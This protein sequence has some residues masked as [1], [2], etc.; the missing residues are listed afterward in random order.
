MRAVRA[1]HKQFFAAA[2]AQ[3]GKLRDGLHHAVVVRGYDQERRRARICLQC[4]FCSGKIDDAAASGVGE[5]IRG[6]ECRFQIKQRARVHGA[7]VAGAVKQHFAAVPTY[8]AEHSNDALGRTAGQE[9]AVRG[10]KECGCKLFGLSDG[11]F[12][13]VEIA[14]A[15][16]FGKVDR[17]KRVKAR[18]CRWPLCPG[19]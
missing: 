17:K 16:S 1:V 7:F 14:G 9:M 12:G 13:L 4:F 6:Q 8:R 10:A 19:M 3:R 2:M 15:V 5:N 18:K 11:A